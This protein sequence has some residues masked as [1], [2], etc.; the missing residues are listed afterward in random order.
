MASNAY[1]VNDWNEGG[2]CRKFAEDMGAHTF[3]HKEYPDDHPYIR[4]HVDG[5]PKPKSKREM[6]RIRPEDMVTY[7]RSI[8]LD[9]EPE[10]KVYFDEW[11]KKTG[12]VVLIRGIPHVEENLAKR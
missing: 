5:E 6:P 12:G 10:F 4:M 2:A 7:Y 8:P 11:A 1:A 9:E 3:V